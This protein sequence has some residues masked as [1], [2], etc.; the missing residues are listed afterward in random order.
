MGDADLRGAALIEANLSAAHLGEANLSGAN[1]S[2][3]APS[4]ADL[5]GADLLEA[6]L[7][8]AWGWNVDQLSEAMSL[9]GATMPNGQKYEIWLKSR[10][11]GEDGQNSGPS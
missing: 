6:N 11:R 1:L 7:S 5:S 4:D 2:G 9:E 8:R 3:A 10:D